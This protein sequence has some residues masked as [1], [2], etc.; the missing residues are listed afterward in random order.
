M[1]LTKVGAPTKAEKS[2][3]D[4]IRI[5][6][7]TQSPRYAKR[8]ETIADKLYKAGMVQPSLYL[9]ELSKAGELYLAL[10]QLGVGKPDKSTVTQFFKGNQQN[11]VGTPEYYADLA[12]KVQAARLQPGTNQ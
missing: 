9:K 4:N 10:L 1:K 5:H 12:A 6:L 2:T 7:I 3:K 11:I 8:I